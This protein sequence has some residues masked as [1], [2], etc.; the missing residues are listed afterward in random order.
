[1]GPRSYWHDLRKEKLRFSRR[2]FKGGGC[3]VWASISAQGRVRLCFVSKK[4]SGADYRIVLRRGIIPFWRRNRNRNY[5]FQHDGAPIHKARKT[6]EFLNRRNVPLL[7]WPSC[8]PD[9]NPIENVWA[10]IVKKMYAGDKTYQNVAQ[11]KRAIISAWHQVDQ[12]L[13]DNL[14]LSMDTRI[15][16]V[17]QRSG[18]PTDY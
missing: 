6:T 18:G 13:L 1:M 15:F 12:Q 7:D 17:V 8:S 14:Y 10:F 9:I 5:V 3:M 4:M 2:N 11:L 16:Q